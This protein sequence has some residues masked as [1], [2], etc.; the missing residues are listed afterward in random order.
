MSKVKTADPS[1]FVKPAKPA[2][3]AELYAIVSC[4]TNAIDAAFPLL[5]YVAYGSSSVGG[6]GRT[7]KS[8]RLELA[9]NVALRATSCDTRSLAVLVIVDNADAVADLLKEDASVHAEMTGFRPIQTATRVR[10]LPM[11]GTK[12]L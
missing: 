12:P 10:P 6:R 5:V 8:V 3:K 11:C 1:V 4:L 2:I 9:A 7:K